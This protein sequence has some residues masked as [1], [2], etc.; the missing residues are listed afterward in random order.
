[1]TY[2]VIAL[3][4]GLVYLLMAL[5]QGVLVPTFLLI[6]TLN[7]LNFILLPW[8]SERLAY[9]LVVLCIVHVLMVAFKRK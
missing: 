7:S 8:D 1:M 3:G 9:G 2:L 4:M 5:K 6:M